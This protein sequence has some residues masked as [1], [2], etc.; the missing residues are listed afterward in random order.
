[1]SY[2]VMTAKRARGGQRTS[3]TDGGVTQEVQC[4]KKTQGASTSSHVLYRFWRN[5]VHLH[6]PMFIV[7]DVA[8]CRTILSMCNPV[9]HCQILSHD[10]TEWRLISAT[11]CG[12]RCCFMADQLRF[13]TRIRE[14]EEACVHFCFSLWILVN[15]VSRSACL[16]C[17]FFT[18]QLASV[19]IVIGVLLLQ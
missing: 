19:L 8:L 11:L 17:P 7:S 2:F 18:Y 6:L 12:W 5:K 4:S 14:E 1:M 15:K 3:T 13:M 9:K 16:L 10:K